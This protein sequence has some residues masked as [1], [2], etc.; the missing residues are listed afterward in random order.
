MFD[1]RIQ[2]EDK[3][4][5][6]AKNL[7]SLKVNDRSDRVATFV[8]SRIYIREIVYNLLLPS[9]SFTR[10]RSLAFA[11]LSRGKTKI[12]QGKPCLKAS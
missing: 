5:Y 12:R 6:S 2:T 3:Y 10:H 11:H 4:E 8:N 7:P 9:F 1:A